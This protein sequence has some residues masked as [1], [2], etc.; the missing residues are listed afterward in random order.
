[1]TYP[2]TTGFLE[3]LTEGLAM[4]A[5]EFEEDF[6]EET[7]P[8]EE[9]VEEVEEPEKEETP[10]KV[11]ESTP[12]I[13]EMIDYSY[14]HKT[15]PIPKAS[16]EAI[17]KALGY[18]PEEVVTI[19]Q[20][21][22][23][24]DTLMSRQQPYDELIEQIRGYATDNGMELPDAVKKMQDALDVVSAGKY[25]AELRQKYPNSDPRLIQDM[26]IRYAREASRQAATTRQ[27]TAEKEQ[28]DIEEKRWT[29]FFYNHPE[30]RPENLSPRML[31]ALE[32]QEDPERVYMAERLET[33]QKEY[34]QL[35][36]KT[37]N[38]SRS[39]GSAKRTSSAAQ[40]DDFLD[41]FFGD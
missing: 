37:G 18:S 17:G 35:K 25:V 38:E 33:L 10:E 21:G 13:E 4:D 26:A 23:N 29:D 34:D 16:V 8:T 32:N 6:T 27:Q 39:T 30:A 15:T 1:M 41:A 40:K 12:T 7:E 5:S 22:S 2:D 28:K 3:G 36:Q 11:E 19:L 24:Y 14:N 31:Q 9:E 20:K